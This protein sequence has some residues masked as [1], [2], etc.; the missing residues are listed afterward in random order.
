M[1]TNPRA[2]AWI[3][4]DPGALLENYDRLAR[5]AGR[6]RMIPMVK[7]NAYGLGVADA[8][9]RLEPRDPMAFG[10]ATVE[11]G[12]GL[13]EL[14]VRRP[15]IVFSPTPPGSVRDAVARDLRLCIGSLEAARRVAD[16]A[17]AFDRTA[18]VHVEVDT[19]MGR[20]GVDWRD[21][22]PWLRTFTGLL[23]PRVRWEG[24]FTHLHSA[25]GERESV[26]LQWTR[27]Q[28]AL[29][30]SVPPGEVVRHVLNSSGVLRTPEYAADAV[31]PGIFLYGGSAGPDLP[32]PRPVLALRARVVHV[33]D[34]LEGSTSGYGATYRAGTRERW[35][36]LAIGYGDGLP[37]ALGNRGHALV[38]G[39]RVP[40]VG[41]VSMDVSVVNITGVDGV[42][43]GDVATL[44]GRDG[45]EEITI[46][47]VAA[48]ADTI[49]YEVMTGLSARLPRVWS[50]VDGA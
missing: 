8:V 49:S 24:C 12:I 14:G 34:A 41:R 4:L 39:V 17:A 5:G 26:E 18:G 40:V 31:R 50:D 28:E 6:A 29:G 44:V 27:F 46:E 16:A 37:R 38:R 23:G 11:E 22:G 35:A 7:A 3:E 19:G 25:D 42:G 32:P 1:S 15:V 20:S 43:V 9:R 10:V 30:S 33:K 21:A 36:T 2:R 45:G 13:R 47:D 48:V